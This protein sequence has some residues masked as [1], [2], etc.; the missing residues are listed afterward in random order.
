MNQI[1][2]YWKAG[3][4]SNLV[5]ILIST[6][7]SYPPDRPGMGFD[8]S[9]TNEKYRSSEVRWIPAGE[10]KNK[11]IIDMF[12]KFAQEANKNAFGFDITY[13]DAVQ[14]TKYAATENGQYNWHYD[15]FWANPTTQ[16]RK[17]SI[18]IQLS[19]SAD[20]E[21]GDFQIDPQ[22]PQLPA[23]EIR[24]KG[25]VLVFPSFISHRVTPVTKGTRRSL[26]CWVEGPKFR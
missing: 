2:Q 22:L 19:D 5:D 3:I 4:D 1:W 14:Y 20:Y 24:T 6:G 18:V 12:W 17:L 11:F 15:T 23:D 25:T 13:I 9:I 26:V 8:G 16:D 10:S 7:D 21:G